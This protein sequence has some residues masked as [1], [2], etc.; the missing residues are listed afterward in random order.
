MPSPVP[1]FLV[2]TG[3]APG[4]PL[5]RSLLPTEGR[6]P[7][8]ALRPKGLRVFLASPASR[9]NTLSANRTTPPKQN[10]VPRL[11]GV[12]EGRGWTALAQTKNI[13]QT[14]LH[15]LTNPTSRNEFTPPTHEL[16]IF[17]ENNA[18]CVKLI[19]M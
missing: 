14:Q 17:F 18:C 1:T 9:N 13:P 2:G 15:Q 5:L 12:A 3:S 19:K 10:A 4:C 11:A 7:G 6:D 8:A 16:V